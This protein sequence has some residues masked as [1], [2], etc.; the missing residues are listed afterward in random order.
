MRAIPLHDQL[1]GTLVRKRSAVAPCR[2]QGVVRVDNRHQPSGDWDLF[3]FQPARI[4]LAIPTLV[5]RVDDVL[6]HRERLVV[7]SPRTLLCSRDHV[8]AV[9]GMLLHLGEFIGGE[10]PGFVEQ[11]V[12][13]AHLT[14]VVQRRER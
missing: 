3:A 4:P 8:Q 7:A 11:V 2:R 14:D 9:D 13:H 1:H 6:G 10:G 5:M 12:W